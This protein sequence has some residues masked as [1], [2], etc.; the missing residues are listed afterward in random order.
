M[1]VLTCDDVDRAL[2]L[3]RIARGSELEDVDFLIKF[4][5]DCKFYNSIDT[6]CY[7]YVTLIDR[8]QKYDDANFREKFLTMFPAFKKISFENILIGGGA[9]SSITFDRS[10]NDIDIFF[11]GLSPQQATNRMTTLISQLFPKRA[12]FVKNKYCLT[13]ITLSMTVQFIFRCYT[14]VSQ[15]LHGFDI[16]SSAAGFDGEQVW[17]TEMGGLAFGAK[18]NVV[19]LSRRSPTYEKRL[20]KYCYRGFNIMF[21]GLDMNKLKNT[22][23]IVFPNMELRIRNKIANC[24]KSYHIDTDDNKKVVISD[25]YDIPDE[26]D[27]VKKYTYASVNLFRLLAGQL[28]NCILEGKTI[29]SLKLANMDLIVSRLEEITDSIY[30]HRNRRINLLTIKKFLPLNVEDATAALFAGDEKTFDDIVDRHVKILEERML[31]VSVS[32]EWITKNPGQQLTSSISPMI[33]TPAEWYGKY[34]VGSA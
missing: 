5:Q 30:T 32:Y 16:G 1:S 2:N 33:T 22:Q 8:E 9:I 24:F 18:V 14:C 29:D 3:D 31:Q 13:V 15:I 19:D 27:A 6:T 34:Y 25:E 17:L 20:S 7:P 12:T 26:D 23:A 21:P 4:P 11:Y 10:V 28:D